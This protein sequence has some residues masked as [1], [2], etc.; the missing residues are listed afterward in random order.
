MSSDTDRPALT[1]TIEE[2][3]KTLRGR[4]NAEEVLSGNAATVGDATAIFTAHVHGELRRLMPPQLYFVF[5][6]NTATPQIVDAVRR[7]TSNYARKTAR[8]AHRILDDT[9]VVPVVV[10]EKIGANLAEI[11][12]KHSEF[13]SVYEIP[14]VLVPR[15]GGRGSWHWR[16]TAD[17]VVGRAGFPAFRTLIYTKLGGERYE[18]QK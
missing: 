15:E 16:E 5:Y 14:V 12:N 10:A 9:L 4:F 11:L 17:A 3:L 8:A 2:E 18:I 6:A 13:D 7:A 1:P